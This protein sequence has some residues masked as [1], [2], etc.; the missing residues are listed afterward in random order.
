MR[1]YYCD[2]CNTEL[3]QSAIKLD[4]LDFFRENVELCSTCASKFKGA[5]AQIFSEYNTKYNN[6]RE[7]YLDDLIDIIT[8]EPVVTPTIEGEPTEPATSEEPNF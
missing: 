8:T 3:T 4:Y 5:K 7:D 2:I 1:K 6:L